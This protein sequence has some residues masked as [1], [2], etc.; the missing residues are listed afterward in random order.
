MY[1]MVRVFIWDVQLEYEFMD[2]PQL[3]L[4]PLCRGA[5]LAAQGRIDTPLPCAYLHPR[6]RPLMDADTENR[7][8]AMTCSL[9]RAPWLVFNT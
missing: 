2:S 6:V 5:V 3:K 1:F 4:S 8:H 7:V 9:K